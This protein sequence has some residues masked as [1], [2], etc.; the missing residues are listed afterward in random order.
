MLMTPHPKAAT[1]AIPNVSLIAILSQ[2]NRSSSMAILHSDFQ[3][4]FLE[5]LVDLCFRIET[6]MSEEF[7]AVLVEENLCGNHPYAILLCILALSG[8]PDVIKN[9]VHLLAVLLFDGFH[10]R[11]HLTTGDAL[12]GSEL[13]K[14]NKRF[15]IVCVGCG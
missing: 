2:M 5:K 15:L 14:R 10:H 11:L 13:H 4:P 1:R 6:F 7:L 8:F 9:D 12:H 3:A